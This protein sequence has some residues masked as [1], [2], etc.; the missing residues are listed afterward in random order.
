MSGHIGLW[1]LTLLNCAH[2]TNRH[3][4]TAPKFLGQ[5][6]FVL[7]SND[8]MMITIGTTICAN[9]LAWLSSAG[10]MNTDNNTHCSLQTTNICV[11]AQVCVC[12][13][14]VVMWWS[15]F[16]PSLCQYICLV[17][18]IWLSSLLYE[19]IHHH[20]LLH[21]FPHLHYK[22][23]SSSS[24]VNRLNF[25]TATTVL[26]PTTKTHPLKQNQDSFSLPHII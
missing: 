26:S 23:T 25:H 16:R 13:M 12:F 21:N 8:D 17:R 3:A 22:T 11:C 20:T 6:L 1:C 10:M 7:V 4:K 24:Q 2:H 5:L 9:F 14:P 15:T 19:Y 18:T